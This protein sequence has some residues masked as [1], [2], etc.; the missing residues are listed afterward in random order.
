[1]ELGSIGG[2]FT[3]SSLF[4]TSPKVPFPALLRQGQALG[5]TPAFPIKGKKLFPPPQRKSLERNE[6]SWE[7][8]VSLT[9]DAP[10]LHPF[11]LCHIPGLLPFFPNP[12]EG[13]DNAALPSVGSCGS[14]HDASAPSITA[15]KAREETRGFHFNH[16]PQGKWGKSLPGQPQRDP[17][18]QT[19]FPTNRRN[20]SRKGGG[21]S[22]SRRKT[23]SPYW[24]FSPFLQTMP[25]ICNLQS[26]L[27]WH[28][29]ASRDAG[30]GRN[31]PANLSGSSTAMFF[32]PAARAASSTIGQS[33]SRAHP[34]PSAAPPS[35]VS[36]P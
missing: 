8:W 13:D 36:F 4:F 15:P 19:P 16:H 6:S 31:P 11:P 32:F 26:A 14:S 22:K 3:T 9:A 20:N 1:M 18:V 24:I 2:P 21:K 34:P 17:F 12:K 35:A 33:P 27:P 7:S 30:T 28:L 23:S 5:Q 25:L 29:P 10:T